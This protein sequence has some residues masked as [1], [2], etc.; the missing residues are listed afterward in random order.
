MIDGA[1]CIF[2]IN[3]CDVYVFMC[4]SC[5][6]EGCN[7]HLDLPRG[8]SLWAETFLAKVQESVLFAVT[9]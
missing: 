4:E 9:S 7:D 8:V 5:I 1:K 3:I 2:E 6:F